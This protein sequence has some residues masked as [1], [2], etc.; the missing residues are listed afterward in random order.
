MNTGESKDRVERFVSFR[1]ENDSRTKSFYELWKVDQEMEFGLRNENAWCAFG[2][3]VEE[4]I[5]CGSEFLL[6]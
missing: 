4:I 1:R 5:N 3:K 2:S 6:G